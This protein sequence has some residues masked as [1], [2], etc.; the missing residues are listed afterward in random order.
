MVKSAA[1]LADIIKSVK[2]KRKTGDLDAKGYY[3][4]QLAILAQLSESLIEELD[5]VSD[6][7]VRSQ[8]PLLL[9]ILDDQIR[10][11]LDRQ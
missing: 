10:A 9:V 5:R 7:D 4:E 1:E 3:K 6:D 2:E 11:F 8:I